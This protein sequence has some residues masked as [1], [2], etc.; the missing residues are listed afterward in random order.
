MEYLPIDIYITIFQ[1]LRWKDI[2]S[3][4]MVSKNLNQLRYD[5][6]V[7]NLLKE[8][9]ETRYGVNISNNGIE[10]YQTYDGLSLIN[11]SQHNQI[12]NDELMMDTFFNTSTDMTNN[13]DIDE[14]ENQNELRYEELKN[15]NFQYNPNINISNIENEINNV[16]KKSQTK[17]D[18]NQYKNILSVVNI[19]Q[20]ITN[21]FYQNMLKIKYIIEINELTQKYND[22]Y[23]LYCDKNKFKTGY[24]RNRNPFSYNN[25][26]SF[27][28]P[29]CNKIIDNLLNNINNILDEDYLNDLINDIFKIK[30]SSITSIQKNVINLLKKAT[31]GKLI[32]SDNLL[33]IFKYY[34]NSRHRNVDKKIKIDII[35]NKNNSLDNL[36]Y[37]IERYNNYIEREQ[38][39]DNIEILL[40]LMSH[41]K[42]ENLSVI[43]ALIGENK[44]KDIS[45]LT[46]D[47]YMCYLKLILDIK[48]HLPTQFNELKNY[49]VHIP[50][51]DIKQIIIKNQNNNIFKEHYLPSILHIFEKI[52]N[53]GSNYKCKCCVK[54]ITGHHDNTKLYNQWDHIIRMY[55]FI[56]TFFPVIWEDDKIQILKTISK[57]Y[58]ITLL[59]KQIIDYMNLGS[60]KY[61]YDFINIYHQTP[62]NKTFEFK[63]PLLIINQ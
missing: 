4:I 35:K 50:Y 29:E 8:Q 41:N 21:D 31:L 19:Y 30:Y 55:E 1:N 26:V 3:I 38:Y 57:N 45:Y 63:H 14:F 6:K 13:F 33:R 53:N 60:R 5:N 44:I 34:D 40:Y 22:K 61:N 25:L 32:N 39:N 27:D 15:N 51:M 48:C 2:L 46:A 12:N 62:M 43:Q 59:D 42:P 37:Y 47:D 7:V 56:I 20:K 9:L 49:L 23:K 16:V 18:D 24:A 52:I 10:S 36:N 17:K 58:E 28:L 11:E 54:N